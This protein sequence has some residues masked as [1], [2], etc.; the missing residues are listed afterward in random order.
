MRPIPAFLLLLASA[1]LAGGCGKSHRSTAA[2]VPVEPPKPVAS[3]R[4]ADLLNEYKANVLAADN[5][6][7]GKLIEVTGKYAAVQK[8]ILGRFYASMEGGSDVD[9]NIRCYLSEAGKDEAAKLKPNQELT[10]IGTC[11][12]LFGGELL[13]IKG[14]EIVKK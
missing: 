3:V 1:A 11:D 13:Q 7:K 4:A 12:G 2:A 14:C 5:K 9:F 6:Y 8:D 10:V